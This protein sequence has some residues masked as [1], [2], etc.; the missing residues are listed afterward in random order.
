MEFEWHDAKRRSNLAKHGIDFR[1]A[2]QLFDDRPTWTA[3]SA[4]PDEERYLTVGAIAGRFVAVVWT[5]RGQAIRLI[6]ARRASDAEQRT[7]RSLH[8]G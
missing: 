2:S 6:S 7:Y 8:G 5:W 1:T 4:Y 3:R